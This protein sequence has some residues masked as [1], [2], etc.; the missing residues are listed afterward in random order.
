MITIP[1]NLLKK[2]YTTSSCF[3]FIFFFSIFHNSYAQKAILNNDGTTS[4]S[5]YNVINFKKVE[6]TNLDAWK[7]FNDKSDYNHPEFGQ[8][9]ETIPCEDCVEVLSK[10][11]PNERYFVNIK[12]TTEFFVQKAYGQI[13]YLKDGKYIEMNHKIRPIG[14]N[15]YESRFYVE[16][17]GIDVGKK[18]TYITTSSGK[19]HFNNWTLWTRTNGFQTKVGEANWQNYT[20]GEEGMY[21]TNIFN[22]IDAE[23][24]VSRG[25][26]KTNFIIKTNEY[27]I[28][29]D[30]IFKDEFKHETPIVLEFSD[31]PIRKESIGKVLVKGQT[32]LLE[33]SNAVIYPKGMEKEMGQL[34]PYS[35]QDNQLGVV[36]P[37]TWID[38][39]IGQYNLIIDPLVTGTGT[40]LWANIIGSMYNANCQFTNSCN[41]TVN[42]NQ[43]AAS[44]I[45]DITFNFTY[46][47]YY[48][49][50]KDYGAIQFAVG[51]CNHPS[52]NVLRCNDGLPGQCVG[53]NLSI[54]TGVQG[55][56]PAPSCVAK[57]I[58]IVFKF[59]RSCYGFSG[60]DYDCID[61]DTDLVITLTGRTVEVP[62]ATAGGINLT[63]TS[64]CQGQSMQ[65]TSNGGQF[66]VPPYTYN[67]SFNASGAPSVGATINP[68][69][70][71]PTIGTPN[72]YLTVTDNCGVTVTTSRTITV[73]PSVTSSVSITANPSGP[74][75]P[76]T[77]VT[78]TAAAV[79]GGPSPMYQWKRNGV[80]VGTNAATYTNAALVNGDVI[81]VILTTS[82][83]CSN[84]PVTSPPYTV[85][86][87]NTNSPIPNT[88]NLPAITAQCTTTIANAS[89][90]KATNPCTGQVVTATTSSPLTFSSQ[91]TFT[92]TWNYVDSSGNTASQ[93][94]QVI[95]DDIANPVPTVATL[96]T[97]TG[98]CN[99]T[100]TAPTATDNCAGTIIATTSSPLSYT[101][102]GTFNI[103]WTYNDGNG[104]TI[105][106]TQQ[107]VV[108]DSIPPVPTVV[109]LPT[110]TAQCSTTVTVPKA[111]DNCAGVINATTTGS[112]TFTQSG[113]I[114]WTYNDGNG[115][116]RTQTQQ[117]VIQDNVPPVP[118]VAALPTLSSNCSLTVT[119]IPTAMDNCSGAITAAT[120]SP[121]VY[122]VNGSYSITWVYTDASGN[123]SNQ[124]QT[125]NVIDTVAPV[126]NIPNLPTVTGQC[127][128][129]ITAPTALDNCAGTIVATTTSPLT[130]TTEGTYT[131]IWT[132]DDGKGNPVTQNQQVIIYDTINPV[133][134]VATLPAA[135]GQCSV[136]VTTIP[137]AVDNCA[138]TITA[139]TTSPLTYNQIG[140]HTIIW[141]YADGNGNT[142]SQNQ[143]VEVQNSSN[144]IPTIATLTTLTG[145]CNFTVTTIPTAT[146]GCGGT[147]TATTTSPLTYTGN[148]NYTVT[149]VYTDANGNSASQQQSIV[150]LDNVPPVPTIAAL[151]T[152][153]G[154][155]GI[156]VTPPNAIDNCLGTIVATTTNPL[157]YNIAGTFTIVWNYSDA[158]GNTVSQNQQV[159]VSDTAPPV[160]NLTTLPNITGQCN[161]SVS[162][163]PTATDA[164]QG[165]ITATTT[166]P[167]TYSGQGTYTV[168][169]T[170]SDGNGNLITQSQQVVL[171]DPTPPV[172]NT[173]PAT[174]QLNANGQAVLTASQVNNNSTDNCGIATL[175]IN[176]NTFT[177]ANL[178]NNTIILTVTD[179]SG[180]TNTNSAVVTVVD[181]ISPLAVT[182][183]VTLYLDATG[184]IT[185]TAVQVDNGS[186]DN[187]AVITRTLSQTDFNCSNIG[188]NTV[189]LTVTDQSG[190][191][192]TKPAVITILETVPP[193]AIAVTSL[194]VSLDA[195]GQAF[196]TVND[197]NNG[198]TDNCAITSMIISK[199]QF[200]CIE[201]GTNTVTLTVIDGSGNIGTTTAIVNVLPI[202]APTTPTPIQEFCVLDYAT[203]ADILINDNPVVW[204]TNAA[205]TQVVPATALLTSGVYYAAKVIGTCIGTNLL[206]VTININ[207]TAVPI[208]NSPEMICKNQ[209]TTLADLS[210]ANSGIIWYN[211]DQGGAPLS[212]STIVYDGDYFYVAQMGAE[213]ESSERVRIDIMGEYCDIIIYNAV[214][215]NIDGKND[216]FRLEGISFFPEN[217]VEIFNEWGLK[218]YQT[219]KYGQTNNVFQGYANTGI[220]VAAQTLLPFGTY[221]YVIQFVNNQGRQIQKTGY[222]HLTH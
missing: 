23:V 33:V 203:V 110:I 126:P 115:N 170:Y 67:W 65:V 174:I 85:Q 214:S 158:S 95:I 18:Q 103:T 132:Y 120:T 208:V 180:N 168:V 204:Y 212:E 209:V 24:L 202:P 176:Q 35:I 177:C 129:T 181:T 9:V 187:C 69:I 52:A 53:T 91:G 114:T 72:L 45:T 60:C 162:V 186:T 27:G 3:F 88:A 188:T 152:A 40:L 213:C 124:T 84:S 117:V 143:T 218:V 8:N 43:P 207:D 5:S 164:C 56:L 148:G 133:P 157:V 79:N 28:F 70:N 46:I 25:S 146:D 127:A 17:S 211:N 134:S 15:V 121:L 47:A 130:Y 7:R 49:C 113:T 194:D 32:N 156:T 97:I 144:P 30:L 161:V 210:I 165:A 74:I 111:N 192:N 78:F 159:V 119:T 219:S 93:T 221:Y 197:I 142:I 66:G 190:N 2:H 139:T 94:Q 41:Y 21:I 109:T 87:A 179:N 167:L 128:A 155:C 71:F 160:P 184:N 34:A 172:A 44:T 63:N 36:V 137:T 81:T 105:T 75:C 154:Q 98:Q 96:P 13:N 108:D 29:T 10:R 189:T 195:N 22:G 216:Y 185:L 149:W 48:P 150:L 171:T 19:V 106:Q 125:V 107:V 118:N 193:V 89:F 101:T 55:C 26:I 175:S 64:I 112:L 20:V 102:Q 90:P 54:M 12:D 77:S 199:T 200:D 4:K 14:N 57:S 217:S 141:N 191:S 92:I 201:I 178:G 39:Y 138:G 1:L 37:Y 151:P 123:S 86:V 42:V 136:T 147:V 100:A 131:V 135:I 6:K 62:A 198:S 140:T 104:N 80:N 51:S 31:S 206:A 166:S 73:N 59:F 122:T 116:T 183:P 50:I 173:Q 205:A 163:F 215:A 182:Q 99:A 220:G 11:T 153:S 83:S 38:Q 61:A 196:I 58:P 82:A 222:L 145:I 169:W 16:P 76:G 68:T